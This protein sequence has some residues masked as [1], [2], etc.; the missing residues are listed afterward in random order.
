M[1]DITDK[2]YSNVVDFYDARSQRSLVPLVWE[3]ILPKGTTYECLLDVG[4]GSGTLTRE[5]APSF[6]HVD[7]IEPNRDYLENLTQPPA[8]KVCHD[9]LQDADIAKSR[10]DLILC[11]H[12]YYHVP[13]ELWKKCLMKSYGGL[14][15]GGSLVLV[16]SATRGLWNDHQLKMFELTGEEDDN[17]GESLINTVSELELPCQSHPGVLTFTAQE[18]EY[19][20]FHFMVKLFSLVHARIQY[21]KPD[22]KA[23]ID[24]FAR[25]CFVSDSKQFVLTVEEDYIVVKKPM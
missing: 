20:M 16:M 7:V 5:L 10:Y 17:N 25:E 9:P 12:I 2:Q 1:S 21:M 11:S 3:K 8:F 14:K 6:R 18:D 4:P 13:K 22:H 23:Q 24:K 19:Q 15:P